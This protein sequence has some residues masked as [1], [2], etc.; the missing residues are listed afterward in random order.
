MHFNNLFVHELAL[1]TEH[2]SE[3]FRPP[4]FV[5]TEYDRTFPKL[6]PAYVS[7]IMECVSAA[8]TALKTFTDMSIENARVLPAFL[9][10]R[11]LYCCVVMIKL[12]VS[13]RAPSSEIGRIVDRDILMTQAY[14]EKTLHHMK[15][16][17]GTDGKCVVGAK[18]LM[19][20]GKLV[21]WFR[22][23]THT[24]TATQVKSSI[25][26]GRGMSAEY[27]FEKAS[28][29]K[30]EGETRPPSN[31]SVSA[32][33]GAN[34]RFVAPV[35]V[36]RPSSQQ[37]TSFGSAQK[38]PGTASVA[39]N[40]LPDLDMGKAYAE[41]NS[42]PVPDPQD[43]RTHLINANHVN[44]N[45]EASNSRHSATSRA[46]PITDYE[47]PEMIDVTATAA[48]RLPPDYPM[49]VDPSFFN[50]LEGMDPFTTEQHSNSWA[51][52]GFDYMALQHMEGVD[53]S[54]VPLPE[55]M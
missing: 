5:T 47:S 31:N 12:D 16:V 52:Q 38:Q 23:V 4:F 36:W 24:G 7:A 55:G 2:D 54:S 11:V 1:H 14:I 3:D 27:T 33:Q 8:Q 45:N 6:G 39:H 48:A 20:L 37:S 10:A 29:A 34:G 25:E 46:S 43:L 18:F 41:M 40:G 13:T 30:Q 28:P 53:W 15:N 17:V 42:K 9:F 50:Q 51:L 49:E 22:A 19:V 44:G 32:E 21:I 35:P 26:P